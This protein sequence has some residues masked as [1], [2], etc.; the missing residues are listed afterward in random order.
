MDKY[1]KKYLRYHLEE[2]D[3]IITEKR[4]D[5]WIAFVAGDTTF[6][7]AGQTE[8]QAIGK[9]VKSIQARIESAA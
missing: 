3:M 8:E 6:W 1:E 5:D 7:E 2:A 9:L 4:S